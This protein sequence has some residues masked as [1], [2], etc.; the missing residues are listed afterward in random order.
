MRHSS[1]LQELGNGYSGTVSLLRN[2]PQSSR[3]TRGKH[4]G[5][6][7]RLPSYLGHPRE[8]LIASRTRKQ[9]ATKLSPR[10]MA[11]AQDLQAK[12]IAL[13]TSAGNNS[14]CD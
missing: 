12:R 13:L 4:R 7:V 1:T 10:E 14:D 8:V 11:I 3:R 2:E 5:N 6:K 9:R